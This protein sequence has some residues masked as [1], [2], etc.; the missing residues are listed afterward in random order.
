MTSMYGPFNNV[1]SDPT[2]NQDLDDENIHRESSVDVYNSQQPPDFET[3]GG[4]G[5]SDADP[6]MDLG[7]HGPMH[8]GSGQ[9]GFSDA[10]PSMDLGIHGPMHS[11]SGQ[12]GFSDADP[13][14]DLGIHGPMH[15]ESGQYGSSG[16]D[17]SMDLGIHGPMHSES[18]QYGFS[19][20][21][22]SMDLGIQGPMHSGSGQYGFSDVDPSMDLGIQGPMHSGSGQYGFSDVD[23]SMN[24]GIQGPMHSGSNADLDVHMDDNSSDLTPYPKYLLDSANDSLMDN[25]SID[26]G[27]DQLES[28]SDSD[29][30]SDSDDSDGYNSSD[31]SEYNIDPDEL[32]KISEANNAFSNI[33]ES[34]AALRNQLLDGYTCLKNSP[35]NSAR[36]HSIRELTESEQYSLQHYIAWKKSNGTVKAYTLHAQVLQE[37]QVSR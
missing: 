34:L 35:D 11:E 28:S 27:S 5:F 8:S 7:I 10:D 15:S 22:P 14:M 1:I 32:R 9:Y 26:W 33:P 2:T 19:D 17:P 29:S 21:D 36:L 23:P 16:A 3:G 37:I 6:S 20:A 31:G 18:G 12:Y 24:L 25:M 4:P 30:D 13:S